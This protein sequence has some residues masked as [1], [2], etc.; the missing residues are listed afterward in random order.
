MAAVKFYRTTR[1]AFDSSQ[2][3]DGAIYFLTDVGALYIVSGT[4]AIP[5]N[6]QIGLSTDASSAQSYYGLKKAVDSKL[7]KTGSGSKRRAYGVSASNDQEMIEVG[8][9]AG[10]LYLMPQTGI[11][12]DSLA[13]GVRT[14]LGKADTAVQPT[15]AIIT[16]KLDAADATTAATENKVVKRDASG[17]A[18]AADFNWDNASGT[19]LVNKNMLAPIKALAAGAQ[20]GVSFNSYSAMI[21]TLNAYD[22]GTHLVIGQNIYIQTLNVPD[23][24]V[25]ATYA[26]S[27]K[28]TYTYTTDAAFLSDMA[29]RG[30]SIQVGCY[31]LA[32]LETLKV[33]ISGK[34]DK[35]T[36]S[37]SKPRVYGI[38]TDGAEAKYTLGTAEGDVLMIPVGGVAY[39][40][41]LFS[42]NVRSKLIRAGNLSVEG[43]DAIL[44]TSNGTNYG[45]EINPSFVA[46]LLS[47]SNKLVT[48]SAVAENLEWHTL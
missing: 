3:E 45:V 22:D 34:L 18:F 41:P 46:G 26:G 8:T 23:L 11:A 39:D 17:V 25:T 12:K 9:A 1:S 20:K 21:A 29:S 4:T 28:E 10:Q 14:S 47:S 42:L 37:A 6:L 32:Q 30:G 44:V 24:W 16:G 35:D 31:V 36:T 2:K 48:Q 33:D 19:A 43:D 5:I 15:D 7:T 38:A 40:S 13:E 27:E